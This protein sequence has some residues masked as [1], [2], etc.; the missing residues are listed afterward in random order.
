MIE[1][2]SVKAETDCLARRN[3]LKLGALAAPLVMTFKS[4]SAWALSGGC[5]LVDGTQP[6]PG[7]F[8]VPVP[9]YTAS[10]VVI[11]FSVGDIITSSTPLTTDEAR[12]LIDNGNL[13]TSCYASIT[14]GTGPAGLGATSSSTS[15]GSSSSSGGNN[16]SSSGASSTSSSSSSSSGGRPH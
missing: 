11:N 14:M 1:N 16:A 7:T 13:S 4:S 8:V 2:P 10:P 15:S 9:P 12:F 5:K 6:I 3:L